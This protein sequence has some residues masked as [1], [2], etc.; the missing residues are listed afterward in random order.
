MM[1]YYGG[2]F[3]KMAL[4][5]YGFE[6]TIYSIYFGPRYTLTIQRGGGSSSHKIFK[7]SM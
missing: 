5:D 1:G 6:P 2:I 4:L 3:K 7:L